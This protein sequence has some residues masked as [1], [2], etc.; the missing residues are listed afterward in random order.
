MKMEKKD[1]LKRWLNDSLVGL[2][3]GVAY[4]TVYGFI[5]GTKISKGEIKSTLHSEPKNIQKI[6]LSKLRLFN[7][8]HHGFR[9]GTNLL[10][11][12]CLFSGFDLFLFQKYTKNEI[13]SKTFSGT[14]V[15]SIFG[16]LASIGR[17]DYSK[18]YYISYGPKFNFF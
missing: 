16:L 11:F 13:I 4:G 5:R 8:F 12:S 9:Y 18:A 1:K 15:G 6:S 14:S 2:F 17:K 10:I 7:I 3:S